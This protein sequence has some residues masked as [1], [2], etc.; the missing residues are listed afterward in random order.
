[1]SPP[2][3]EEDLER[4]VRHSEEFLAYLHEL[5][6][7]R[8]REPTDDL[9][10]A[11]VQAEEQGGD[12]LSE[13]ELYSMVV[14]LIVAGHETTVSL[15]ANAVLA[16]LSHPDELEKL[17]EDP[18]LM[19]AAAEELLRFDSPV[20]RTL[21]RWAAADVELGGQTIRRGELV[22]AVL[23]SANRD[24]SRYHDAHGSISPGRTRSTS[25][26]GEAATSASVPR[27][28]G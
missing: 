22:I 19:P 28:H 9:V 23:G 13:D 12:S 14:L 24:A 27:S 8:R 10:T 1:M 15:I 6:E 25:R 21:T 16:L 11:L 18:D 7:R 2:F 17:Q 20:E 5:F 4:F 26:S 3:T